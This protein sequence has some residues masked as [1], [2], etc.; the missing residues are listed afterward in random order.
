MDI[1]STESGIDNTAGHGDRDVLVSS[2][3]ERGEDCT[4]DV[5]ADFVKRID[6]PFGG[7][8]GLSVCGGHDGVKGEEIEGSK[9]GMG[10]VTKTIELLVSGQWSC[11]FWI[12][13]CG[14]QIRAGR[15][16]LKCFRGRWLI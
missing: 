11:W 14:K 13:W 16:V 7:S 15:G 5:A 2:A 12:C 9:V 8:D 10:N 6:A 4:P 3:G 1:L